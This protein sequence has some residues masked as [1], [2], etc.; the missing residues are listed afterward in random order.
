MLLP[1]PQRLLKANAVRELGTRVAYDFA[2]LQQQGEAYLAEVREQARGLVAAAQQEAV[3]IQQKAQQEAREQGRREGL[4][5]SA[6]IIDDQTRRNVDQQLTARVATTLPA[7]A[8][9]AQAMRQEL[10]HWL[11]RW[12]EIAVRTSVAIAEKIVR[13]QLE[14]KPEIAAGM[15]TAALQLAAGHPQL[16][17]HLHPDDIASLGDRA[18]DVVRAASTC[19]EAVLV[20]DPQIGRGGCRVETRHGEIDARLD[21]MLDRIVEELLS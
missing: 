1:E 7:V 19:A 6:R 18:E 9:V 20:P 14:T 8:A 4:K 5:E 10:D 2:D 13:Q 16:R 11:V 15:I 21:T 3:A 12:E 17:V